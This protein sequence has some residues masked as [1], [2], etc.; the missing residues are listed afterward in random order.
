MVVKGNIL[1]CT[2]D[3]SYSKDFSTR[4]IPLTLG[5]KYIVTDTWMYTRTKSIVVIANDNIH[6]RFPLDRFITI[7]EQRKQK[8]ERCS[9]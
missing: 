5:K 6:W 1:V 3:K 9:K 8:L 4:G 2:N 7:K